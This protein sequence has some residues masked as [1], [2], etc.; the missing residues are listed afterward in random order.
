MPYTDSPFSPDDLMEIFLNRRRN[1]DSI[2]NHTSWMRELAN[3]DVI[4]SELE[5]LR[6]GTLLGYP[7]VE[8]D[9]LVGTGMSGILPLLYVAKTLDVKWLAVR[10]NGEST[11]TG[12]AVEGDLGK[13]WLF[14]D[15]FI[16]SGK[17]YAWTHHLVTEGAADNRFTTNHAGVYQYHGNPRFL[18]P[19]AR[20]L[21]SALE[22]YR[23]VDF[24][25]PRR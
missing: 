2:G 10:K 7:K 23:H 8:F 6:S 11:H 12:T 14:L 18:S 24:T 22:R 15:D 1:T 4:V 25:S 9:T 21:T 13:R 20:R 16:E 17:T 3:P 5:S 19:D